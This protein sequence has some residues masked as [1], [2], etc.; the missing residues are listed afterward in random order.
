MM[1]NKFIPYVK[2]KYWLKSLDTASLERTNQNS[3]RVPKHLTQ[4]LIYIG[5]KTLGTSVI[6]SPMSSPS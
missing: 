1:I 6:Y 2:T 4:R 5:N 3:I